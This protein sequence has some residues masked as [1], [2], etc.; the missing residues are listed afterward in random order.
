M[1]AFYEAGL[2]SRNSAL[3]PRKPHPEV[4]FSTV[5]EGSP[6]EEGEDLADLFNSEASNAPEDKAIAGPADIPTGVEVTLSDDEEL[7]ETLKQRILPDPGE[8]TA[9]QRDDHRAGGHITFRSWCEDCVA[10]RATG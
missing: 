6:G 4:V 5:G 9:S 1:D 7:D 2:N 3:R 10:G 8:P